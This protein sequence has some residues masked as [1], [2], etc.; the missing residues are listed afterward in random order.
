VVGEAPLERTEHGLVPTGDGWFV[1]NAR[2]APWYE[3]HG[4]GTF[5]TFEGEEDARFSHLGINVAVLRPGEPNCMYHAEGAQEDFLVLA[6]E[7]VLIV[8]GEERALRAWDFVHCPPET[9]HV[10]VGAGDGP[11]LLLAVGAR[12][13]GR[14]LLYPVNEVALKHGAGV[15]KETSEGAEAYAAYR[16][17]EPGPRPPELDSLLA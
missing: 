3:S 14:S 16:L 13:K 9:E 6:G 12:T 17:P 2:D 5:V 8:E 11:C 1:L 4:L 10:F 7:C 15:E